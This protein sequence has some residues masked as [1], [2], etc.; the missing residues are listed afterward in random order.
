MGERQPTQGRG[1]DEVETEGVMANERTMDWDDA[2]ARVRLIENVGPGEYK[3][4]FEEHCR[5]STV[6]VVNGYPIRRT[7]SRFGRLFLVE[8]TATAFPTLAEA[9]EFAAKQRR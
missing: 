2:A 9:K 5:E 8:G 6:L 3:R 4:R 1:A 7:G